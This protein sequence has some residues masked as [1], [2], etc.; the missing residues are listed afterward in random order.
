MIALKKTLEETG[1]MGT[2]KGPFTEREITE[3]IGPLWVPCPRFTV[4]QGEKDR[5]V[6]NFSLYGQN[7]TVAV[8]WKLTLG[9]ID[10]VVGLASSFLR[11]V[12]DDRSIL[13][14]LSNGRELKGVLADDLT[15]EQARDIVA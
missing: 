6:D 2:L 9:G 12:G 8:P 7:A 13:I 4:R 11:A 5:A 10:E 14:T 3:K 1:S 15:I